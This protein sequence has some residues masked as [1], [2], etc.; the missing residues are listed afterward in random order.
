MMDKNYKPLQVPGRKT[1][2]K[3]E[4]QPYEVSGLTVYIPYNLSEK[5]K[6]FSYWEGDN[7]KDIVIQAIDKFFEGKEVKPRPEKVRNKKKPGKKSIAA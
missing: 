4:P 3:K 2:A 5:L 1:E 7:Q 6:D